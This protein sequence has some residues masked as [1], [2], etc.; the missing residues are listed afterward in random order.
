MSLLVY[1]QNMKTSLPNKTDKK[2]AFTLIE[3]MVAI[4][5]LAILATVGLTIFSNVQKSARDA[6]RKADI[7]SIAQSLENNYD[8]TAGYTTTLNA[9]W[10][11]AGSI[12]ANPTPGGATYYSTILTNAFTLRALLENAT[13]GNCLSVSANDS[14][15]RYNQR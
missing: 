10:F 14:Y 15:C 4:A 11:S 9:A 5:I 1:Q 13:S 7:D 6:R 2:N 8:A 3:L 12:P